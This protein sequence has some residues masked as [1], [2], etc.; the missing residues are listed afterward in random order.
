[1]TMPTTTSKDDNGGKE[2]DGSIR[3]HRKG[4]PLRAVKVVV[5]WYTKYPT[6][7]SLVDGVPLDSIGI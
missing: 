4:S 1:M 3:V 7:N 2:E 5:S 6:R